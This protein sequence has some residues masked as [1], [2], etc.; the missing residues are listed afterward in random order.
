VGYESLLRLKTK[1]DIPLSAEFVEDATLSVGEEHWKR[2]HAED[3]GAI[4]RVLQQLSRIVEK[5]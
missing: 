4:V 2:I 5:K 3:H 1:I